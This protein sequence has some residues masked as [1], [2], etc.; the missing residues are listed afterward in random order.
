LGFAPEEL[1]FCLTKNP[2][3]AYMPGKGV[4]YTAVSEHFVFTI[5]KYRFETV[6][7]PGHTPG[8]MCLYEPEEKIFIA[9]DHILFDITPNIT[10]WREI[11]DSLGDYMV[12]LKKIKLY[13][14][15]ITLCGHRNIIGNC[16][17]RIDE[18]LAHHERRLAD[19][20]RI[21][22]ANSGLNAYE[23]AG[24]MRWAIRAKSWE[25]FPITQKW[26]AAGEAAAHLE[27]LVVHGQL[28]QETKDGI[29]RYFYSG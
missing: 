13:D 16:G 2:L 5:G 24:Q 17:K 28:R 7:T 12:S 23:V 21:V 29:M 25:D 8:H 9:G 14:I 6:G 1:E 11:P 20:S 15:G 3:S 10:S 19:V 26:F 18:L 27:H 4:E 22:E